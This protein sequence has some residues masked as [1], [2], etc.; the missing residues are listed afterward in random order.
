MTTPPL[1]RPLRAIMNYDVQYQEYLCPICE[2]LCNNVLPLLPPVHK[3]LEQARPEDTEQMTFDLWHSK[4]IRMAKDKVLDEAK[5]VVFEKSSSTLP[6]I[7]VQ[8]LRDTKRKAMLSVKVE[9][10][11]S[12]QMLTMMNVFAVNLFTVCTY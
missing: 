1:P 7:R 11:L 12:E 6:R 10:R 4:M 5:G 8:S 9:R 3:I 2:R